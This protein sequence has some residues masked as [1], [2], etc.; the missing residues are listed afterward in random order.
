MPS[1]APKPQLCQVFLYSG[2]QKEIE[3]LQN[4][5]KIFRALVAIQQQVEMTEQFSK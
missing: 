1:R 2:A 3:M 4:D 5:Q